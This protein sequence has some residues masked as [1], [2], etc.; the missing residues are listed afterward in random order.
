VAAPEET[1]LFTLYVAG[2]SLTSRNAFANLERLCQQHIPGQYRIEIVDLHTHPALAAEHG[3][4]AVPMVVREAPVP[5]RKVVGDLS[6]VEVALRVL[7]FAASRRS[8]L[9]RVV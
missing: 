4:V 7:Q 8:L 6:N 3:V 1:W 5:I 2:T 9:R